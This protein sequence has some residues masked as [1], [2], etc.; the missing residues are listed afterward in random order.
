MPKKTG[1]L[2]R[3]LS[4][5]NISIVLADQNVRFATSLADKGYILDRGMIRIYSDNWKEGWSIPTSTEEKKLDSDQVAHYGFIE[6]DPESSR[7]ERSR[8]SFGVWRNP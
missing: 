2:L 1:L 3:K 5:S 4:R 6:G 7:Q 8:K